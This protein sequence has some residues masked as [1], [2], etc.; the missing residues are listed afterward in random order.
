M[1][2]IGLADD[3][4]MQNPQYGIATIAHPG[5]HPHDIAM[6]LDQ[7]HV[8]IRAGKLCA[9][10]ALARIAQYG[11]QVAREGQQASQSP[12]QFAQTLEAVKNGVIR[13]SMGIYTN[14]NDIRKFVTTYRQA[15]DRLS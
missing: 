5:T 9:D 10:N 13:V 6:L 7:Q 3:I 1:K 11:Q 15:I 4:V 14:D 8:I 12:S 2:E